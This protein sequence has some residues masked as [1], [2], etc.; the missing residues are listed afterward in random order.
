[1]NRQV[2]RKGTGWIKPSI[3]QPH[4]PVCFGTEKLSANV[5]EWFTYGNYI[6]KYI[7]LIPDL[8]YITGYL[9]E[10]LGSYF[11]KALGTSFQLLN[12]CSLQVEMCILLASNKYLWYLE[13]FS[14]NYKW[15]VSP[16]IFATFCISDFTLNS[17]QISLDLFLGYPI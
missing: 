12:V 16:E 17:I 5:D 15:N 4:L 7:I 9:C 3:C 14:Q 8:T 13:I 10:W 2:C 11:A 6:E 1:M